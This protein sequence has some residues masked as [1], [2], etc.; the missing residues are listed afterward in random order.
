MPAVVVEDLRVV[1]G[2]NVVLPGLSFRLEPGTVAGV[3]G[4]SGSGKS[5]LLRS[6]VGV[7]VVA[8]G[9]VEVLGAPAGSPALRR[10]VAYTTQA[11]SVYGD[12]TLRENLTYFGRLVR[13]PP[14]AVELVLAAVGIG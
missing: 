12:L 10:R 11:P 4:P 1:R 3:L 5:T 6:L 9:R 13:A 7:Q 2:G 14:G 8:A